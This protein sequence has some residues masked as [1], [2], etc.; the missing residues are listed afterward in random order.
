MNGLNLDDQPRRATDGLAPERAP[1]VR[2][3]RN[4][5]CPICQKDHWC[6]VSASGRFAI[7]MRAQS[8]KPAR[9]GGYVHILNDGRINIEWTPPA[10]KPLAPKLSADALNRMQHRFEAAI[11]SSQITRLSDHLGVSPES[12]LALQIGWDEERRSF[13]FP[14]RR[15]NGEIC[16]IRLRSFEKEHW[17]KKYIPGSRQGL[18]MPR[19][20]VEAAAPVRD[21]LLILEGESD[22][23]A[24]VQL[25]FRAIGRPSCDS[26]IGMTINYALR[27]EQMPIVIIADRD[28]PE[29]EGHTR[30]QEGAR[31]LAERMFN[32]GISPI[33]LLTLPDANDLRQ[34]VGGGG[35]RDRLLA[36]IDAPAKTTI[37]SLGGAQ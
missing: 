4:N 9:G 21:R 31:K 14:N 16:G 19:R 29:V 12:L 5:P 18:F 37:S 30:G 3:T 22:L 34:W 24:A 23:S 17:H 35:T 27:L 1:L 15:P 33:R 11:C 32:A 26:I 7:C 2:V 13:T 25:G 20:A 6:S 28:T 10:P 36:I 8:T